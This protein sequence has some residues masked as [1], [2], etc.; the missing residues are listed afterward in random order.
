MIKY[1]AWILCILSLA[2]CGGDVGNPAE[3]SI[4]MPPAGSVLTI[5]NPVYF[6][7][8]VF[9]SPIPIAACFYSEQSV[10]CRRAIDV[11]NAWS[12]ACT[13]QVI[14]ARIN[15]DVPAN[16]PLEQHYTVQVVPTLLLLYSSLERARVTGLVNSDRLAGIMEFPRGR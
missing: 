7:D 9:Q 6:N 10:P 16:A 15:L 1:G 14:F 12:T 11:F 13:A 4:S 5:T 3:N 2:G 8:L